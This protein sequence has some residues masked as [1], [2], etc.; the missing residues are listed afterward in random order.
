MN[1]VNKANKLLSK[2]IEF[3]EPDTGLGNP[4]TLVSELPK[5]AKPH[6]LI[7]HR[8]QL[9]DEKAT[10]KYKKHLLASGPI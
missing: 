10:A 9:I 6:F 2:L 4:V 1:A 8:K 5:I 7:F 3:N